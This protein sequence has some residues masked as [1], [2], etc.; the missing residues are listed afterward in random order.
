MK[1]LK[2]LALAGMM[3]MMLPLAS[4][5]SANSSKQ[6]KRNVN[7][8]DQVEMAGKTLKPGAYTVEWQG[9]GPN[10]NVKFLQHGRTVLTAPAKVAQ[11]Q[12]KAPYDAVIENTRKNGSKTI[13]EI[14]WN[15]Q[16]DA[17]MFGQGHAGA[18][19]NRKRAS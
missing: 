19:H 4:L 13:S 15:N 1:I 2:F 17:L 3:T 16:R 9:N 12:Q 18:H 8:A 11:L 14:E 7:V 6:Q 5:A 10:V